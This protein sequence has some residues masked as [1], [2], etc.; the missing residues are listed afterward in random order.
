[1]S[2][3]DEISNYNIIKKKGFPC[4]FYILINLVNLLT[5]QRKNIYMVYC[6]TRFRNTSR[7]NAGLSSTD[8]EAWYYNMNHKYRGKAIIFNHEN[9]QVRD[10]KPRTGT[11]LDCFNLEASLKK[12]GF[13]VVP[14]VDLT[15]KEMDEKLDYC[16]Y[17]L[18]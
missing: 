17:K 1:M 12:L 14:Y 4:K 2:K 8:K 13:D 5:I 10:L 11:G 3:Y 9:F 15:L 6:I 18:C 16:M 7:S